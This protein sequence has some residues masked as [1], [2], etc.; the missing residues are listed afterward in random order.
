M[1]QMKP[2]PENPGRFTRAKICRFCTHKFEEQEAH[3]EIIASEKLDKPIPLKNSSTHYSG[4]MGAGVGYGFYGLLGALIIIVVILL[5]KAN[6]D[7]QSR[8]S[9]VQNNQRYTLDG[10]EIQDN[11]LT[12]SQEME[13]IN[14]CNER[15]N[16]WDCR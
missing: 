2:P 8:S 16:A 14:H 10:E 15:P 12:V 4:T 6:Q 3:A 11:G 13:I 1:T 7:D 5:I 9:S